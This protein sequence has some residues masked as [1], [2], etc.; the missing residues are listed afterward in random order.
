M[1][2]E[3]QS[4]DEKVPS[5]ADMNEE[6]RQ[7]RVQIKMLELQLEAKQKMEE[8][9]ES[10]RKLGLEMKSN[11]PSVCDRLEVPDAMKDGTGLADVQNY[12]NNL[13]TT[14]MTRGHAIS[15][16]T[17]VKLPMRPAHRPMQKRLTF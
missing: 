13:P 12:V 1:N 8:Y 14:S 4:P 3:D 9:N 16:G 6:L 7:A 17:C 2:F 10:I 5:V 11:T 15:P